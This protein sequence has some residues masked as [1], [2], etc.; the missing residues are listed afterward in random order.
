MNIKKGLSWIIIVFIVFALAGC[1]ASQHD[2]EKAAIESLTK[3]YLA[4]A[5]NIDYK[6]W[7]GEEELAFLAPDQASSMKEQLAEF[8]ESFTVN[9]LTQTLDN[10]T[11]EH[12]AVNS[13]TEGSAFCIFEVSGSDNGAPYSQKIDSLIKVQKIDGQWLIADFKV[14]KVE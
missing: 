2:S 13:D 5:Y 3:D 1:S 8:K 7:T 12:I 11:I 6:T 10:L 9:Q 14:Q 4:T